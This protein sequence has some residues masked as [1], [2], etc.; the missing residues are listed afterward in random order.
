M[1]AVFIPTLSHWLHGNCWSGSLGRGSYYVT[2]RKREE[3]EEKIPELYA[4][5]WTGPICHEQ[6]TPE[7]TETFAVTEDGIAALRAWLEERLTEI[8]AAARAEGRSG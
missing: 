3:G 2:P 4:E 5:V 1:D 8:D 6:C 7:S